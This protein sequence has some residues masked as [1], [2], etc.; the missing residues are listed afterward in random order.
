MPELLADG[1]VWRWPTWTELGLAVGIFVATAVLSVLVTGWIL[2]RL[3]ANY[4]VGPHAPSLWS[5]RHPM[6]QTFGRV[7]KNLLGA[8]LVIAGIVMLFV[9]GQGLLTILI[10]LI[11]LDL[12]GK[13]RF[14]QAIVRRPGVLNVINALRR[15]Y[16]RADLSVD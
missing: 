6:L 10:G 11:F 13:R 5:D 8:T 16:G 2:V 1:W 7:A 14:E 4:F 15:R 12:P 3:P 9:P